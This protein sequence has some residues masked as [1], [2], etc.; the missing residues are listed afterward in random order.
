VVAAASD[1]NYG[2]FTPEELY[3]LDAKY[4][5]GNPYLG[6]I[7]AS[8]SFLNIYSEPCYVNSELD[9]YVY[10]LSHNKETCDMLYAIKY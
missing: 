8:K 6:E 2:L 7:N 9:N 1:T 3:K 4:D 5:D 10:D